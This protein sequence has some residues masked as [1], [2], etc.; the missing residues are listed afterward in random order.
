MIRPA[1]FQASGGDCMRLHESSVIFVK[2]HT[3]LQSTDFVL[4]PYKILISRT[5]TRTKKS[6]FIINPKQR[7]SLINRQKLADLLGIKDN[8]RLSEYHRIFQRSIIMTPI[9]VFRTM[10][11]AEKR[12]ME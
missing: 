10:D 8:D 11:E 2:F 1:A 6:D 7:H 9:R 3:R 12:M 5:S 4:V